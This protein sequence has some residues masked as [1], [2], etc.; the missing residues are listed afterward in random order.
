VATKAFISYRGRDHRL[1]ESVAQRLVDSGFADRAVLVPPNRLSEANELL[2]PFEYFELMEFIVDEMH[3]CTHFVALN[4]GDYWQS[5]WTQAEVGHWRQLHRRPVVHQ[6]AAG[7]RD[8]LALDAG[9]E[10]DPLPKAESSLKSRISFIASRRVQNN[11]RGATFTGRYA[12][13]CFL[14]PCGS[15]E[16][17]FLATQKVVCTAVGSAIYCPVCGAPLRIKEMAA[18]QGD[19]KVDLAVGGVLRL[20]WA[21][22]WGV[23]GEGQRPLLGRCGFLHRASFPRGPLSWRHCRC[24]PLC[25]TSPRRWRS[26]RAVMWRG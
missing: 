17:H 14:V 2:L 15:C 4:R 19:C 16:K 7:P 1:A 11:T 26:G 25:L 12:K 6:V 18:K 3:D 21:R 13:S 23:P 22:W 20:T 8:D 10:L 24:W 5:Y 9:T